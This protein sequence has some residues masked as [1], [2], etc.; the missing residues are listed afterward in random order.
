MCAVLL[1][2][3]HLS[4]NP[5]I[6]YDFQYNLRCAVFEHHFIVNEQVDLIMANISCLKP[7]F[8]LFYNFDDRKFV[9][10]QFIWTKYEI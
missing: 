5:I 2:P 4:P 6:K 7:V 1:P 10:N 8:D 9:A 3:T